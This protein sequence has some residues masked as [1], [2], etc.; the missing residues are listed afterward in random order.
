MILGSMLVPTTVCHDCE[1]AK[2][3]LDLRDF[4]IET[5]FLQ[6][7][8]CT[9]SLPAAT[10]SDGHGARTNVIRNAASNWLASL[11]GALRQDIPATVNLIAQAPKTWSVYAPMLLLPV[12]AFQDPAWAAL[13]R[14]S[15][16]QQREALWRTI[17]KAVQTTDGGAELTHIAVN[18]G[19]PRRNVGGAGKSGGRVSDEN[20]LRRPS[21]LVL[22]Y[23]DFGPD[24]PPGSASREDL[25][26]A[27]W[28]AARQNGIWQTWAPRYTMFSRG[29]VKE[30][31]RILGFPRS[32][33][34]DRETGTEG[35]SPREG[36]N[37]VGKP[38]APGD[39]AVDFYAG[40]GY[41]AF[42]YAKL[43][44]EKVICWEINPWSV[45]GLRRGAGR[46]GWECEIV[47][48]GQEMG[49]EVL[50]GVARLIVFQ[51]TNDNALARIAT[52]R[53]REREE[54]IRFLGD[55]IHVNCGLL[56]T[57]ER[58][59]ESAWGILC[60]DRVAWMHLHENVGI[61]DIQN[62][63]DEI[64]RRI[65]NWAIREGGLVK[66]DIEHVEL[67]KTFAPGVWHC[68]FDIQGTPI[69]ATASS[70]LLNTA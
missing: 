31:A 54:G 49:L 38:L 61:Q 44:M 65:N 1:G 35:V 8:I 20:I 23:G 15:D 53:R 34:P 16:S 60:K 37:G 5:R 13:L 68:V 18:A 39:I 24:I 42:S 26:A 29:N 10:L 41:F 25:A 55:V 45:E 30:K 62:R 12:G 11:P 33:A 22:L 21:G 57:S 27:F 70:P 64:K 66:V 51:E 47:H 2:C 6:G 52:V 7:E 59:W 48:E 28:V 67:V 50:G 69:A 14:H 19:I 43:G 4:A 63:A 9:L 17:L 46:N 58:S 56:P 32:C 40:I 36:G 3:P